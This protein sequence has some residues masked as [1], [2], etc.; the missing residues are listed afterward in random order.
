MNIVYV[1]INIIIYVYIYTNIYKHKI[2][3]ACLFF[4]GD[5]IDVHYQT[6]PF[7][8]LFSFCMLYKLILK[9]FSK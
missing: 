4:Y 2:T 3:N 6:L 8:R 1:C 5:S 9:S 7:A